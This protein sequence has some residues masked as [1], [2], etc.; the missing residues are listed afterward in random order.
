ML[1]LQREEII[2]GLTYF[3]DYKGNM[4]TNEV[5]YG[6]LRFIVY[7]NDLSLLGKFFNPPVDNPATC[8]NKKRTLMIPP[9]SIQNEIKML[10]KLKSIAEN[11]LNQYMQKYEEDLELMKSG[12]KLTINH[13]NSIVLR[14]GEK[15]V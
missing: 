9:V 2:K 15:K 13:K 1:G 5:I 10:N 12:D 8:I 11:C 7:E 4:K 6:Y 3:E 14:M